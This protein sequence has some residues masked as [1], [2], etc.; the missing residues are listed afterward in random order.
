MRFVERLMRRRKD[1]VAR[2]RDD[3]PIN[4]DRE[5]APAICENF[6]RANAML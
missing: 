1:A 5:I 2:D 6:A 4:L 3:L